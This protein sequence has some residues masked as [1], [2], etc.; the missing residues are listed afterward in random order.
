M[1]QIDV[2]VHDLP[3]ASRGARPLL[4]FCDRGNRNTC[5]HDASTIIFLSPFGFS[6]LRIEQEN[7]DF[8]QVAVAIA[9]VAKLVT[10]FGSYYSSY[11]SHRNY[12]C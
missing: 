12:T 3:N 10:G 8:E 9:V 7:L 4:Y 1:I 2:I 6:V 11:N 5:P